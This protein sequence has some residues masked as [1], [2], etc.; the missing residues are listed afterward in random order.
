MALLRHTL[1][2]ALHA[3]ADV[4]AE[5]LWPTRCAV[6]DAPGALICE[7]CRSKLLVID[8]CMACPVCGAPYGR[9]QCTEC[10]PLMLKSACR[11]A[12][13]F[14]GMAHAMVADDAVR[15]IVSAYKDRGERRLAATIAA[16]CAPRIAPSWRT[17]VVAYLPDAPRARRRRGFDHG[18]ELAR[19]VAQ[20]AGLPCA[21]LFMPPRTANQRALTR[22]QRFANMAAAIRLAPDAPVPRSVIV[23]DD[24]CTTGSTLYA[25]ADAL[26]AAGCEAVF[27]LTF[28]RVLD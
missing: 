18:Q 12:I 11:S 20:A 28:G 19:A 4:A 26:R 25:A 27:A 21:G 16:L 14:D 5:T 24:I 1:A 10:T 22:A 17:S 2:S 23:F 8:A 7:A 9:V 6:C 15:R 3:A 13:P